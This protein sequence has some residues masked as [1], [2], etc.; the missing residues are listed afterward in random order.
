MRSILKVNEIQ[1][2][3]LVLFYYVVGGQIS[4]GEIIPA[5]PLVLC[6]ITD[7]ARFRRIFR[8]SHW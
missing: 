2:T 1:I 3:G 4:G 8:S 5:K 6:E 7:I